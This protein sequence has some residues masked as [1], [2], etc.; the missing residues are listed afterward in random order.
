MMTGVPADKE[1]VDW[2]FLSNIL[3]HHRINRRKKTRD[4]ASPGFPVFPYRWKIAHQ[5]TIFRQIGASRRRRTPAN[6]FLHASRQFANKTTGITNWIN[7]VEHIRAVML[8]LGQKNL[9]K[10]T[11]RRHSVFARPIILKQCVISIREKCIRFAG[12]H[13]L[14]KMQRAKPVIQK[15]AAP[16]LEC[17]CISRQAIKMMQVGR[18]ETAILEQAHC[19]ETR[20]VLRLGLTTFDAAGG[21]ISAAIAHSLITP[22]KDQPFAPNA[23]ARQEYDA[24]WTGPSC[25]YRLIRPR[26]PLMVLAKQMRHGRKAWRGHFTACEVN[27]L[28]VHFMLRYGQ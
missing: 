12:K 14:Q 26:G 1:N 27:C 22:N 11:S 13:R 2:P 28:N 19:S 24:T 6:C 9:F 17:R 15:D 7:I 23:R 8:D 21:E 4:P 5:Q 25:T 10:R 3:I 20:T 18:I 16:L